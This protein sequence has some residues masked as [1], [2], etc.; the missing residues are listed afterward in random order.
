MISCEKQKDIITYKDLSEKEKS[1]V[2]NV[3][4]KKEEDSIGY[5][6]GKAWII[7]KLSPYNSSF[8][9]FIKTCVKKGK[10]MVSEGKLRLPEVACT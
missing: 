4:L 8:L 10:V 6:D 2:F 9:K 7:F 3:V 5:R 1:I